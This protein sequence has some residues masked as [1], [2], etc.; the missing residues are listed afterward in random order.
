MTQ[1]FRLIPAAAAALAAGAAVTSAGMAQVTKEEL[2]VHALGTTEGVDPVIVEAFDRAAAGLTDEQRA[3]ALECWS[4][5]AC[6]TGTGGEITVA[7][8]DGFGENVWR[9]VTAMEY[10]MQAL[11]YPEVGRIL[12]SSARGDAAKAIADMR[13]Y[14]AQDVDVVVMF[15]DHGAA[16][17]PTVREATEA[18]ILVTVH[19]GTDVGGEPGV[20]YVTAIAEDLCGLGTAFVQVIA[21]NSEGPT[22]VVELGGTPGNPLSLGWQ[23]CADAEIAKHEDME[24]LGVADTNWT[25]EGTF[26]AVSSFLAQHDKIDGYLYEYADGFRGALRAYEAAERDLDMMVAL[27]TDEQGLFCDWEDAASPGFRI[28]YSSGQNYQSRIALTAAMMK[29]AGAEV[30]ATIDVPFAMKEVTV[31]LCNRDLPQETSV[32]TLIDEEMLRAMFA[33]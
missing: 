13:A 25:Q 20:D 9:R 26:E 22:G 27:R 2:M 19:N 15:A 29:A 3:L 4:S 24:L 5:N 17:L 11:T 30:P 18:G 14:I 28:F 10:I 1:R 8:A 23:A 32:S 31:G 33:N 7:Y 21:E 12:Y 6:D 16:L